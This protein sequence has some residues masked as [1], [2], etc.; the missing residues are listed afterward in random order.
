MWR[1]ELLLASSL[2]DEP[3]DLLEVAGPHF[4]WNTNMRDPPPGRPPC[5]VLIHLDSHMW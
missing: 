5:L 1:T 3:F 4:V 2:A